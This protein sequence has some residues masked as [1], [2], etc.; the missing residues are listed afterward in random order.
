MT[1]FAD[2]NGIRIAYAEDG[3]PD[4][5]AL[6]MSHSLSADHTMW[7]PQLPALVD[8][9][10]VLR[11]DTRGHG[12][13]EVPAGD[14][15]LEQLAD[16]VVALMD[17]LKIDR[18]H[19]CGL[20]M[21]GMI[22]QTLGLRAP[23][24]FLSLTL[25][26]TSSGYPPEGRAMWA[27]RIAAARAHGLAPGLDATIDR[28]FSPGFVASHP[29]VIEKVQA[30][31]LATPVDGYCG[32][33][34]AIS[35]LALTERLGEIRIPTLVIVGEDDP[36]TPVAMSE[37]IRDGIPGAELVVLPVARHLANMEDVDGFNRALRR[38]LN[39]H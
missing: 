35:K 31:I 30:M 8:R 10:R 13:S 7:E 21:G 2:A 24:R 19:F 18:A 4:G 36:G 33:S 28:W 34:A 12:R 22:G 14:Y 11:I 5:P 39:S 15:S 38:F 29:N 23:D 16:D 9:Y 25:C 37:T 3:P 1:K 26:D 27:D 17:S 32:C 20:S 6:V